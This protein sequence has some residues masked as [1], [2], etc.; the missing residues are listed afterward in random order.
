MLGEMQERQHHNH[1]GTFLGP[2]PSF[3]YNILGV[4][5]QIQGVSWV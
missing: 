4:H 5:L 1:G 3:W 2:I